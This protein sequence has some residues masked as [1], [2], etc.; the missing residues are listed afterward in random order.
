MANSMNSAMRQN[1]WSHSDRVSIRNSR[2]NSVESKASEAIMRI[3]AKLKKIRVLSH[4]RRSRHSSAWPQAQLRK[5]SEASQASWEGPQLYCWIASY[6]LMTT[7]VGRN[8]LCRTRRPFISRILENS[9][10]S[11][12]A[13]ENE[14]NRFLTLRA[15][16]NLHSNGVYRRKVTLF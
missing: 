9:R 11:S 15:G 16:L 3:F 12:P 2:Q 4:Q 13:N 6:L 5:A 7:V 1:E 14:Q 8:H 10:Q